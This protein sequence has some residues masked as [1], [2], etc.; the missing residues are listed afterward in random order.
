[1]R[2]KISQKHLKQTPR[3]SKSSVLMSRETPCNPFSTFCF[4]CCVFSESALTVAAGNLNVN[5]QNERP[6][7]ARQ[8]HKITRCVNIEGSDDSILKV[9]I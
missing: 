6:S 3:I 8:Q 4:N 7:N 1:M 9:G 2:K 5:S